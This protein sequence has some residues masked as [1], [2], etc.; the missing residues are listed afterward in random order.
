V[1]DDKPVFVHAFSNQERSKYRIA[2]D[3]KLAPGKHTITFDFAD[4]GGGICKGGTGTLTAD[5]QKAAEGRIERTVGRRF[6]LDETFDV[7]ADT[8]TPLVE[9]YGAH[10]PFEFTGK[11]EKLVIELK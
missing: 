6:S 8:G 2:F 7:G 5:G 11:L 4:D 3:K 1:L 10:M 9:D